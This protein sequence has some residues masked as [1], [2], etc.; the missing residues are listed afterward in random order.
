MNRRVVP[1]N[2]AP[3]WMTLGIAALITI[4]CL[5]MAFGMHGGLPSEPSP[6]ARMHFIAENTGLWQFGWIT[7]TLSAFG[8]LLFCHF[9]TPYLPQGAAARYGLTLVAIGIV[10]DVSA[11]LL[12]ALVQPWIVKSHLADRQGMFLLTELIAVQL[13]GTFGNGAYNAG[14]LML[15]LLLLGNTRVPRLLIW[16]GLPPWIFGIAL[17]VATAVRQYEAA[18]WLTGIAMVWSTSWMVLMA[19][20]VFR[21]PSRFRVR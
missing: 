16:L 18:V 8:L 6:E 17:S 13:T 19:L 14:G 3:L 10:P 11:E 20:T 21:H 15:N 2:A 9:L 12:L 5:N 1:G 4:A 7:W